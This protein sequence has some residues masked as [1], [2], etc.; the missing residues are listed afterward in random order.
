VAQVDRA[1][2]IREGTGNEDA[3]CGHANGNPMVPIGPRPRQIAMNHLIELPIV[4]DRPTP[5]E[6]NPAAGSRRTRGRY[7]L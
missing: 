1:I 7:Q 3:S 6:A 2:G 5:G 4:P